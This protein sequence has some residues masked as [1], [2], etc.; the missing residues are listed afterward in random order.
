FIAA[1]R[2]G[3]SA[4]CRYDIDEQ[5][6]VG[7]IRRS[8]AGQHVIHEQLLEKPHVA[9]RLL[10]QFRTATGDPASAPGSGSLTAGELDILRLVYR[11]LTYAEI[12]RALGVSAGTVKSRVSSI[13]RK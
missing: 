4:Y 5:K 2:A 3:A 12:G 8:A 9:A 7:L 6:L 11:G 10:E 1:F 13:L